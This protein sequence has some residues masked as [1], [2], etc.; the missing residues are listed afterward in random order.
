MGDL[1][2]KLIL[3][4]CGDRP[5]AGGV[6]C[7]VQRTAVKCPGSRLCLCSVTD[8]GAY[9]LDAIELKVGGLPHRDFDQL[10]AVSLSLDLVINSQV[11]LQLC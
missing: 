11:S 7:D 3:K 9:N 4:T 5:V 10:L 1:I 8:N 2:S 6:E